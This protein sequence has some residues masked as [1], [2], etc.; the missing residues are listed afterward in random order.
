MVVSENHILGT[1]IRR[2]IFGSISD[3]D[4]PGSIVQPTSEDVMTETNN[5]E[6]R[7]QMNRNESTDEAALEVQS[8]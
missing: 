4:V 2:Y 7:N 5:Q 3:D 1:F 6:N 8:S